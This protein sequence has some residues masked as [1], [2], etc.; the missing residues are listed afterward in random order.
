MAQAANTRESLAPAASLTGSEHFLGV[1]GFRSPSDMAA[2]YSVKRRCV[3]GLTHASCIAA[4]HL[5]LAVRF[6]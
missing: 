4:Q 3:P 2:E 5:L 1:C 6:S